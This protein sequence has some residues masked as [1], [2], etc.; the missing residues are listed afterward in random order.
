MSE[1]QIA[2][3]PISM[4]DDGEQEKIRHSE[5]FS[6]QYGVNK[7][8]RSYKRRKYSQTSRQLE[9]FTNALASSINSIK[10]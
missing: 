6:P 9:N 7:K 1:V 8:N 4:I 10:V 2:I 3:P 5:R